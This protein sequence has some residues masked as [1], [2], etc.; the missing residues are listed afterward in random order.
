M[1]VTLVHVSQLR[2]GAEEEVG[3]GEI[4]NQ[5]KKSIWMEVGREIRGMLSQSIERALTW[6][7]QDVS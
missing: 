1:Q 7:T 2:R 6:S 3:A 5:R 4:M